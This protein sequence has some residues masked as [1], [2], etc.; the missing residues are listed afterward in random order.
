[1]KRE[2]LWFLGALLAVMAAIMLAKGSAHMTWRSEPLLYLLIGVFAL[3]AL[4]AWWS[5]AAHRARAGV[6]AGV[7]H[8]TAGVG[9]KLE[10][11]RSSLLWSGVALLVVALAGPRWGGGE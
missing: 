2:H 11:L 8:L 7:P 6:G 4:T 10:A 9:Y 1:M 3:A 5:S